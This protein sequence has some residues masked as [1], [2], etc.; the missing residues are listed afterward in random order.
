ML[1]LLIIFCNPIRN[2][3]PFLLTLRIRQLKSKNLEILPI[4]I[5][6]IH[7]FLPRW[8]PARLPYRAWPS[9]ASRPHP[10]PLLLFSLLF[11]KVFI[12]SGSILQVHGPIIIW[13]IGGVRSCWFRLHLCLKSLILVPSSHT[14]WLPSKPVSRHSPWPMDFS[15]LT[16]QR[17][18]LRGLHIRLFIGLWFKQPKLL[19]IYLGVWNNFYRSTSIGFAHDLWLLG[20]IASCNIIPITHAAH[21]IWSPMK[22]IALDIRSAI[23]IFKCNFKP[24]VNGICGLDV[25]L[26]RLRFFVVGILDILFYSL[27]K[28]YARGVL[29]CVD[30]GIKCH[31]AFIFFFRITLI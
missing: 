5:E 2:R 11:L 10:H 6:C 20:R 9:R 18:R 15:L 29:F 8:N 19:H 4:N 1:I 30:R 25:P 24:F 28:A 27:Y 16:T 7:R 17:H 13:S 22:D 21:R 3:L 12:L 26:E 23:V 14:F 31:C